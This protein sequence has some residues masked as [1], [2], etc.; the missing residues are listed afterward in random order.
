MAKP[1]EPWN[2]RPAK[3]S[4]SVT[5]F[6]GRTEVPKTLVFAKTDLHAE[7]IVRVI[8]DEFGKGN[9]CEPRVEVPPARLSIISKWNRANVS[10]F[11]L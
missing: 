5:A 11:P 2:I 6:P 4:A 1:R 9:N 7:I 8:H 3:K 10:V